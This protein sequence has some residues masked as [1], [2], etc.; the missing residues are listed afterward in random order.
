MS[1]EFSITGVFFASKIVGQRVSRLSR[2]D[3]VAQKRI[4]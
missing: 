1:H 4:S 2:W 3:N